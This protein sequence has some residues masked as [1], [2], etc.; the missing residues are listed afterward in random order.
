VTGSGRVFRHFLPASILLVFSLSGCAVPH[1]APTAP[2]TLSDDSGDD[3]ASTQALAQDNAAATAQVPST[4]PGHHAYS[5]D[6]RLNYLIFIPRGYAQS[7]GRRWP[8]ILFL[9]GMGERGSGMA[10]LDRVKI[11]GPPMIAEKDPDFPFLVLSPQC[12]TD[13]NWGFNVGKLKRLLDRIVATYAVDE[14]R[15]YL[16]GF[17]MGGFGSW[18]LAEADPGR[19]AAVAPVAGAYRNESTLRGVEVLR[20]VPVR[21]FHGARD[22]MVPRSA[23]EKL[24]ETL[25]ACGGKVTYTLYPDAD[26]M[27]TCQL[28]YDDPGLYAWFLQQSK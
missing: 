1:P 24:A 21:I 26:H 12:P 2:R 25:R 22:E 27:A 28:A 7:N 4:E 13:S 14:K 15:I 6:S 5:F 9:H 23:A 19:F 20:D 11:H 16:T 18:D 17:S 10:D 8:L 3:T